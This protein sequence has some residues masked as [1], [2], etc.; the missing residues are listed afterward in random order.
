MQTHKQNLLVYKEL[1]TSLQAAACGYLLYVMTFLSTSTFMIKAYIKHSLHLSGEHVW[2]PLY[3]Q[4][5]FTYSVTFFSSNE[6]Q[7][8]NQLKV[9]VLTFLSTSTF[10]IKAYIKHLLH[11]SGEHVWTPLYE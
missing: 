7:S 5:Y 8:T 10:M 2:I 9:Y 1:D 6:Y 4:L 3:E 11:L